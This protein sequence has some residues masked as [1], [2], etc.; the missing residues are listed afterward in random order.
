MVEI[1]GTSEKL[2]AF[3]S[4]MKKFEIIEMVRSGKVLLVRGPE[5]T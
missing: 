4:L 1:T 3:E 5:G 2:D